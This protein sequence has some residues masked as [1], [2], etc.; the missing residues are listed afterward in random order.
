M[1]KRKNAGGWVLMLVALVLFGGLILR[2]LS[3]DEAITPENQLAAGM[4]MSGNERA[5]ARDLSAVFETITAQYLPV[6]ATIAADPV[7]QVESCGLLV[8]SD[9]Y[10]LTNSFNLTP[11]DSVRVVLNKGRRFS[12][13]IVGSDPLTQL[14]L[15][16]IVAKGLPTVKWGD[17]DRLRLGQWVIAIGNSSLAAP[18]VTTAIINAKGRSKVA[19]PKLEDFIHLDAPGRVFN[20]GGALVSL[21]GELIGINTAIKGNSG[22]MAIPANLARRVMQNLMKDGK[23]TRG[24][25]GATAQ[26]ID[27]NLAKALQLKSTLGALLVDIAAGSPAER[28]GL[29]RGDVVLQ[30]ANVP[31]ASA[32]EFENT[33]AAQV[34]AQNV[35]A[36]VW[37]DTVKVVCD[38]MPAAEPALAH[39][40]MAMPGGLKPA[41]KLGVQAQNLSPEMA[42]LYH[43][44]V[45][46]AQVTANSAAARVLVAGDILQEMNRRTI[47]S[48][49]DFNIGLQELQ[50]G[51]VALL[52]VRR[53]EKVFFTGV[54]IGE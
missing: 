17:S 1:L 25:I 26:D 31:I 52:L 28:A 46:I 41:N 5:A 6:V 9:G 40:G 3:G 24:Y 32:N 34:P 37:R 11:G 49:R 4:A 43:H 8:S 39:D 7:R 30:F 45:A 35:Q 21:D 33:V 12:G 22:A 14:A 23:V 54:E 29:Q 18:A 13:W 27:Q 2:G 42:R 51:D 16:K 38:V 48:V 19:L 47:R 44:G 36:V 20:A 10:I 15:V 50:A 53:G